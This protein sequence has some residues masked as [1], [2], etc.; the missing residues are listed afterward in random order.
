MKSDIGIYQYQNDNPYQANLIFG[1]PYAYDDNGNLSEDPNQTYNYNYNDRLMNVI[2]RTLP[3]NSLFDYDHTGQRVYKRVDD[4]NQV[5]PKL[6]ETVYPNKYLEFD[7]LNGDYQMAVNI[8]KHLYFGNQRVG[9]VKKFPTPEQPFNVINL[10]FTDHLGSSSLVTNEDGEI[11][12]VYD[13][14]PYG[15]DRIA[16]EM[17]AEV[18]NRFT[19]QELDEETDLHYYG[20]RYYAAALAKFT[21]PDPAVLNDVVSLLSDPQSLNYYSYVGNNPIRYNDPTGETKAE[22]TWGY[23]K[24]LVKGAWQIVSGTL[25]MSYYVLVYPNETRAMLQQKATEA[26]NAWRA[27]IAD[28]LSK[29]SQLGSEMLQGYGMKYS[30]FEK[31]SDEE[32]GEVIGKLTADVMAIVVAKKMAEVQAVKNTWIGNLSEHYKKHGAE[33]GFAN[34]IDYAKAA[35][36]L[37]KN[38]NEGVLRKVGKDSRIKVWD[39]QNNSF[40]SYTEDGKTISYFKPNPEIHKQG[41]NMDYWNNQ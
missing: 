35:N 20:A 29:S 8:T 14:Y 17:G 33:F 36:S 6:T 18:H 13:Y 10:V 12:A 1:F 32:Q 9:D 31:L 25:T 34:E 40:G 2:H 5:P 19:G 4:G 22:A 11:V 28:L 26:I 24:G 38:T 41:T 15:D 7:Y 39:Q 30:E 23:F 27:T 21:Q 3:I 16:D 37:F